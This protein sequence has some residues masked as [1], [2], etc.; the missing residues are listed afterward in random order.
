MQKNVNLLFS[1][2]KFFKKF[3]N[4]HVILLIDIFFKYD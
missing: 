4:M 2:D 1:I 3:V